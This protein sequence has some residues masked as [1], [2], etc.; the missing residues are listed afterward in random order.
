MKNLVRSMS[1]ETQDSDKENALCLTTDYDK[2][3]NNPYR[4]WDFFNNPNTN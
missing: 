2:L 3:F 1:D 4:I